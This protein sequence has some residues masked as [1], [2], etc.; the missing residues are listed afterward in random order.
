VGGLRGGRRPPHA[1]TGDCPGAES[2]V[3]CRPKLRTAEFW[4]LATL[5]CRRPPSP[6]SPRRLPPNPGLS[7][8]TSSGCHPLGCPSLPSFLPPRPLRRWQVW[9]PRA[10][11]SRG[12]RW[13]FGGVEP[14]QLRRHPF[15]SS[16]LEVRVLLQ[17]RHLA[18][19]LSPGHPTRLLYLPRPHSSVFLDS[20]GEPHPGYTF[21]A[22]EG[23]L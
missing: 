4:W 6:L 8:T 23:W 19:S 13:H 22:K 5:V 20:S 15:P 16:S 21:T 14:P 2:V 10:A 9:G 3:Q 12:A 1:E 17:L 18:L 11:R 7:A